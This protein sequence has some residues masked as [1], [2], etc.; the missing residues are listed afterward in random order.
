MKKT[1]DL[2]GFLRWSSIWELNE[3]V[4]PRFVV[5]LDTDPGADDLTVLLKSFV[6]VLV[7][8]VYTETFD[9]DI[10]PW[11]TAS[12]EFFVIGKGATHLAVQLRKFYVV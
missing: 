2:T 7:R 5:V 8:P 9:E 1:Y 4:A 12:E 3:P 11:F 10:A 6:K